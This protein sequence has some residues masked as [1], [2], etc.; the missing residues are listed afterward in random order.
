MVER[1]TLELLQIDG[2]DVSLRQIAHMSEQR[3]SIGPGFCREAGIA[4]ED[5][6]VRIGPGVASEGCKAVDGIRVLR[7]RID[8]YRMIK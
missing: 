1:P 5:L 8:E 3:V 2:L 4:E 6:K 7:S